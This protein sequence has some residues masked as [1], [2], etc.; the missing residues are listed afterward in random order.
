MSGL[1]GLKAQVSLGIKFL[2][3]NAGTIKILVFHSDNI[4]KVWETYL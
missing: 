2:F 4:Q 1:S 3:R